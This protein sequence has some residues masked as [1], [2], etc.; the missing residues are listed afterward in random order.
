MRIMIV[1][2]GQVGAHLCKKFSEEGHDV[3]LIDTELEKLQN[4]ERDLNIMTVHGSGASV[5]ILAEAGIAKTDLFIAVTDSDE[6][7][8]IACIMSKQYPVATRVARVR[9]EDFMEDGMFQNKEVLGIDMVI[10]PDWAMT[11]ELVSLCHASAAFDIAEFADGEIVLLGYTVTEDNPRIGLSLAELG[12][13]TCS[14]QFVITAIIRDGITI[15]PNGDDLI[16]AKDKIYVM[17]RRQDITHIEKSFS[18][19]RCA[20]K[21]VFIIGGGRIG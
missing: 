3:I 5:R 21:K 18:F 9:N 17:V 20:P 16:L 8:L 4:I 6:V 10:S 14:C 1:G 13:I 15:I 12:K 2:A 7:N 11:R 19:I